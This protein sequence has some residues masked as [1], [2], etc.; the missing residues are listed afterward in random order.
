MGIDNLLG[1]KQPLLF[2]IKFPPSLTHSKDDIMLQQCIV[3]MKLIQEEL[4]EGKLSEERK[5][6]KIKTMKK[7]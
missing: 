6:K 1:R 4:V 2:S 5:G 7:M 3:I